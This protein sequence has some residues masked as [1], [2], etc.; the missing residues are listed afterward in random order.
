MVYYHFTSANWYRRQQLELSVYTAFVYK[1]SSYKG[2]CDAS[3]FDITED[4][5]LLSLNRHV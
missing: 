2:E 3:I 5:L 1:L 4:S